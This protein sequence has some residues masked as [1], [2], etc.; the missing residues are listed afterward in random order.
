MLCLTSYDICV[1]N[2]LYY[3]RLSFLQ[4]WI[5][6]G[7]PN[8]FWISGFYFTQS[9]LTGVLQSYARKVQIPIDMFDFKFYVTDHEVEMPSQPESGVYTRVNTKIK[10]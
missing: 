10:L 4:D 5:D 8:V 6:N 7:P 2:D 3:Y 1:L 9:F